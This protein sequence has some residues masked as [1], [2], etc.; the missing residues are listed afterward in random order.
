VIGAGSKV[1]SDVY[2][3][4]LV[5]NGTITGTTHTPLSLPVLPT[6]PAFHLATAGTNDVSVKAKQTVTLQ[7]GAYRNVTVQ[8]GGTLKL[9]GGRYDFNRL[10][11]MSNANLYFTAA[12]EV[13]IADWCNIDT[14]AYVG[15]AP[16]SSGVGAADIIFYVGGSS[17]LLPVVQLG[18]Q[19]TVLAN[20]YTPNGPTVL[21]D[22]TVVTGA[23]I[24][25]EVIVR[26][27][28]RLTLSSYFLAHPGFSQ[29]SISE[30]T[31]PLADVPMTFVLEQNYPN[32]FNPT[33]TIRYQLPEQR[34]VK[35]VVYNMLGQVVKTL[36]QT[37]Q[38]AGTYIA[39]WDGTN[40]DGISA[41][42]GVYFYQL[43]AGDFVVSKK[44][45]LLK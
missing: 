14:R 33:T 35:L 2:Y 17:I 44:M 7:P 37:T 41:A 31:E 12:T 16:G 32:P 3:N 45:I 15:P 25:R 29:G 30:E 42:G 28:C 21:L 4:T 23:F 19:A 36:V 22:G 11:G 5:N 9:T 24:G 20:F 43:K 39:R 26:D 38:S 10:W 13:R 6:L 27:N 1:S 40:E 34:E 8:L 18:L